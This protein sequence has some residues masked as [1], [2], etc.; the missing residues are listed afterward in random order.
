MPPELAWERCVRPRQGGAE[1]RALRASAPR[2]DRALLVQFHNAQLATPKGLVAGELW[3]Q[4]GKI[5]D[6]ESRFWQRNLSAADR[7]IDCGG[8]IIA[9]GFIDLH[10][11]QAFG[12]DFTSL[13]AESA[14][15][16][17]EAEKAIQHVCEALPAYG[18]TSFCP[19]IRPTDPSSYLRLRTRLRPSASDSASAAAAVV[20]LHLDGP[21][22]SQD[23]VASGHDPTRILPSLSPRSSDVSDVLTAV[24]G[25]LDA[26]GPPPPAIVTLAPE[27]PG[28]L[29][30]V[31]TLRAAGVV[32]GLGRTAANL[33]ECQRAVQAGATM[34]TSLLDSMPPFHHRDPGPMGLLARDGVADGVANADSE[35]EAIFYS[36]VLDRSRSH[37]NSVRCG[38]VQCGVMWCGAVRCGAVRCGAV[39]YGTARCS[40]VR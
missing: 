1:P 28:S 18:V 38:A 5:V 25:S 24:Y 8:M 32:V 17:A 31:R 6:P 15:A 26:G 21:F 37:R 11:Q 10:L 7:R 23:H 29:Q 12:V 9:P 22:L 27:I 34:V 35:E 20:G 36:M 40:T 4:H 39:R 3:I 2:P 30:A 19:T 13:G 16:A 33:A 14:D